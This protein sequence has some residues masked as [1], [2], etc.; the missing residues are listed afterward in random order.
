MGVYQHN[1]N[2]NVVVRALRKL[3][4]PVGFKKGYN[5]LLCFIF[6][7]ALLGFSLARMPY[8]DVF[9]YYKNNAGPG[10][11]Y[12]YQ[13]PVEK[14][15]I[16]LHLGSVIPA[17]FL[18]IF[19]FIPIIR[20]KAILF[21]RM[22]GYTIILLILCANASAIMIARHAFGGTLATQMLVGLLA[23]LTTTSMIFG[24]INI[25][26]LQIEQH[27]AWMLRLWSYLG[28]IITLRLIQASAGAIVGM[29]GGFMMAIPCEQIV[30]AGGP[31]ATAG[32]AACQADPTAW[33]AVEANLSSPKGVAEAMAALQISF[34]MAGFLALIIHMIAVE[35]YLKLTPAEFERLRQVSY[36][37][38]IERGF[39]HPGS[40][41][42]TIDRFGDCEDWKPEVRSKADAE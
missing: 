29:L 7:G 22:N 31:D 30:Y 2:P 36:E 21:H 1:E 9:G 24:Y 20:Y 13:L 3:Y 38:Q 15:G 25:K 39:K 32:Y 37:R 23:I 6:A 19:Q 8:L 42:L 27:R 33:T 16:A 18:V 41:G 40:A 26:R 34:G 11:W 28:S 5:A 17:S 12:Y 14:V 35:L 4:N 10:E